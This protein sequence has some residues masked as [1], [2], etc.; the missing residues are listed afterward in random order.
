MWSFSLEV[1]Q[2]MTIL[3]SNNPPAWHFIIKQKHVPTT[4]MRAK[5]YQ[6]HTPPPPPKLKNAVRMCEIIV[7]D[8][9]I[10]HNF[11]LTYSHNPFTS[12]SSPPD[13]WVN[14]CSVKVKSN[15]LHIKQGCRSVWSNGKWAVLLN[16]FVAT[17]SHNPPTSHH[18]VKVKGGQHLYYCR[19]V[20]NHST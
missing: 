1:L 17:N 10:S 3:N 15:P 16:H 11:V 12:F 6:T 7:P 18:S 8:S 19:S 9:V 2:A 4:V 14:H 5:G 13:T 20:R